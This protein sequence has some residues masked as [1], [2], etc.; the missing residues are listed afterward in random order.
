MRE[1]VATVLD[2]GSHG[3]A[4]DHHHLHRDGGRRAGQP[5]DLGRQLPVGRAVGRGGVR[6]QRLGILDR[7]LDR[8][9]TLKWSTEISSDP[10]GSGRSLD[11]DARA[12]GGVCEVG[13]GGRDQRW[14]DA[15]RRRDGEVQAQAELDGVGGGGGDGSR[16]LRLVGA[17]EIAESELNAPGGMRSA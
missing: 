13:R 15:Q 11:L 8:R 16:A 2:V 5:G 14:R 3:P 7:R 1:I 12:V 6:G 17:I 4:E 10:S 9:A